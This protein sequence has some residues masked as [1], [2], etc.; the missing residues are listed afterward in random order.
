ME[1]IFVDVPINRKEYVVIEHRNLHWVITSHDVTFFERLDGPEYVRIQVSEDSNRPEV[2]LTKSNESKVKESN[3]E[4]QKQ[5][6]SEEKEVNGESKPKEEKSADT[7]VPTD[8]QRSK[9][10]KRTPTW[11]NNPCF[12]MTAYCKKLLGKT[13]EL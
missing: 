12:F 5:K 4:E 10:M 6:G 7:E 3:E 13:K 9:Y 8:L 1:G 2:I 11:D